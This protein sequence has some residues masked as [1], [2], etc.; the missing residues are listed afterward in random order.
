MI[1]PVKHS[2]QTLEVASEPGFSK[3]GFPRVWKWIE[4]LP[5]HKDSTAPPQFTAE[6]ATKA[7]LA[8]DYATKDVFV[9]PSDPLD[10]SAGTRVS[11]EAN[12]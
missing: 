1:W 9:D 7:V 4:S 6:E 2:L 8:A 12:E 10:L 5:P 11:V 3:K